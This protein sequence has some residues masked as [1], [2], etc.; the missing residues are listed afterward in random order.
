MVSITAFSP[1][2]PSSNPDFFTVSNSNIKLSVT[3]NT[4]L[5]C[6]NKYYSPAMADTLVGGDT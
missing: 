4:R 6:T 3:N 5:W 2:H 1:G